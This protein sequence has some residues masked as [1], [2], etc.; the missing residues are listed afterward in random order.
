MSSYRYQDT[1]SYTLQMKL[2][3]RKSCVNARS[4]AS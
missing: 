2:E 1:A 4:Y 3:K